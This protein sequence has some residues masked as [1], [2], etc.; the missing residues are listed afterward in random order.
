MSSKFESIVADVSG[1]ATAAYSTFSCLLSAYML[2]MMRLNS[3]FQMFLNNLWSS[4]IQWYL[5]QRLPVQVTSVHFFLSSSLC[6]QG[7][8]CSVQ[9]KMVSMCSEKPI[10]ALPC[11]SEVSPSCLWN[12]SSIHLT[13]DGALSSFE[14]RS[15]STSSLLSPPGDQWWD[16]L[17][18]VSQAPQHF[19]SSEMA[20]CDGHFACQSVCLIISLDSGMS[21][22]VHPQEFSRVDVG[23]WCIP[24]W[25][26]CS[27]FHL[28]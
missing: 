12:G 8:I 2:I 15:S 26:S 17:G 11:L 19:T 22:A 3:W 24:V 10:W 4:I 23:H 9:F 27:T 28:L 18:F 13:E 16:V 20:I 25:A 7:I 1:L 14:G 21:W 5:Q 6:Q